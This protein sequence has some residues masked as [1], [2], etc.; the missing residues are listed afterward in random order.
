M[1]SEKVTLSLSD[2]AVSVLKTLRKGERS[3][4]TSQAIIEKGN[5]LIEQSKERLGKK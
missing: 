4:W 3:Y 1:A 5:K 2:E